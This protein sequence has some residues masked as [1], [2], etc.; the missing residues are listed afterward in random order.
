VSSIIPPY[1]RI[2]S[3]G[4]N[5]KLNRTVPSA[6]GS[7]RLRD[8]NLQVPTNLRRNISISPLM[9][10]TAAND[11]LKDILSAESPIPLGDIHFNLDY[12]RALKLLL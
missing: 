12:H 6:N 3:G 7:V 11:C 1:L 5:A 9:S 10:V 4:N 8:N 2:I